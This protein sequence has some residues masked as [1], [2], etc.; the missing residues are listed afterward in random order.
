MLIFA[1]RNLLILNANVEA[2]TGIRQEVIP[3]RVLTYILQ[4]LCT[5]SRRRFYAKDLALTAWLETALLL[6]NTQ[7]R[8][9][10]KST[11]LSSGRG[12]C[13]GN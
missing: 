10:V 6:W 3:L 13:L 12:L 9:K 11:E 7:I 4:R 2:A 5:M 8:R 1:R